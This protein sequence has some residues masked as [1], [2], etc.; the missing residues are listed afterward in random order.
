MRIDEDEAPGV[1][2]PF[3]ILFFHLLVNL[4]AAGPQLIQ[5]RNVIRPLKS[6][7]EKGVGPDFAIVCPTDLPP[8][9]K[10]TIEKQES[11][12]CELVN[13]GCCGRH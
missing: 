3:K 12:D 1:K 6:F 4:N 11:S 9:L 10:D 5:L 13:T 8:E 7:Y 2:A